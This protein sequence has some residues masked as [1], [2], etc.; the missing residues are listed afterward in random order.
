MLPK[1]NTDLYLILEPIGI[2]FT[3]YCKYYNLYVYYIILTLKDNIIFF[4]IKLRNQT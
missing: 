2:I 4:F 3:K 1:Y